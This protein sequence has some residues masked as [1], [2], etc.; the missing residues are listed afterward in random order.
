MKIRI[1]ISNMY[2]MNLK[3]KK[4]KKILNMLFK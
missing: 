4:N 1:I 2:N 3:K